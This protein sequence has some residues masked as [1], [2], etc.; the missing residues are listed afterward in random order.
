MKVPVELAR[1]SV[2]HFG[3]H[4]GPQRVH[5]LAFVGRERPVVGRLHVRLA[6][7]LEGDFFLV[8]RF[9]LFAEAPRRAFLSRISAIFCRFQSFVV[10]WTRAWSF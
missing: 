8:L 7:M 5:D 10:A 4:H 3:N 9:V 2:G 1:I 6:H